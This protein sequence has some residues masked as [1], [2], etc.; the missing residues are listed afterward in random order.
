ML[1]CS[2]SLSV[3]H[4]EGEYLE[5]DFV[6]LVSEKQITYVSGA[7]RNKNISYVAKKKSY[8]K[9]AMSYNDAAYLSGFNFYLPLTM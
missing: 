5:C 6:K 3:K 8:L 2:H 4:M 1:M 7:P 9:N